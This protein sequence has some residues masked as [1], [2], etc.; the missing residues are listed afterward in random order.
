MGIA[1]VSLSSREAGGLGEKTQLK[2]ILRAKTFNFPPPPPLEEENQR[3]MNWELSPTHCL[4]F[5][6]LSFSVSL[7]G[8]YTYLVF[9]V[10]I[11]NV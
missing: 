1:F 10:A 8:T 2:K 9:H 6:L 7:A 3:G 11:S 5:P 4:S